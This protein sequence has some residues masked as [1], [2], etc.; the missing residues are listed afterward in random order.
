[1]SKETFH[2]VVAARLDLNQCAFPSTVI[3]Q[4]TC[5]THAGALEF[6]ERLIPE[7]KEMESEVPDIFVHNHESGMLYVLRI[8]ETGSEEESAKFVMRANDDMNYALS[9]WHSAN[10]MLG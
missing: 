8:L 5:T 1:M 9:H 4:E 3:G 6:A 2:V 7:F 10:E